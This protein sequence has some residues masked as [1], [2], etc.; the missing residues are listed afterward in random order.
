M[1]NCYPKMPEINI[2][3]KGILQIL[4]KLKP[5]KAPGP[6]GIRPI[7]LKELSEEIAPVIQLLFQK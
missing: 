2:Y 3:L 6:D 7:I 1:S 5:D 4:S